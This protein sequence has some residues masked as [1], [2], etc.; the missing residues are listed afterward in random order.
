MGKTEAAL[1]TA[2]GYLG[3]LFGCMEGTAVQLLLQENLG[4]RNCRELP[5]FKLVC[6]FASRSNM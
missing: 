1:L 6:V 5:L 2:I 3:I 4:A